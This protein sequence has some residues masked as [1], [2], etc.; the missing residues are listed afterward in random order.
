[1]SINGTQGEL[2][3]RLHDFRDRRDW[4]KFHTPRNLAMSLSIECAELLELF[5][6]KSD[7]EVFDDAATPDFEAKAADEIADVLIYLTLLAGSL[8]ID[9]LEAAF[10]K[11]ERNEARFP[12]PGGVGEGEG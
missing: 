4:A 11:V 6:W 12:A 2:L 7:E 8:N 5:Q 1:M 3:R 9:P 10:A